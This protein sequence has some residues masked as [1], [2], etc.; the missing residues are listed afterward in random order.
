M[1]R[2]LLVCRS[3]QPFDWHTVRNMPMGGT[4]KC[5]AF[6]AEALA[7]RGHTVTLATTD[8]IIEDCVRNRSHDFDVVIAQNAHVFPVFPAATKKLWW[9]HHFS[10]QDLASKNAA[11]ARHHATAVVTLS[12]CH[13]S[14]LQTHLGI[15]STVIGHGVWLKDM[16]QGVKDPYRLIYASTPF[17]GLDLI[18]ALFQKIKAREPRATMAI[19]SGMGIYGMADQD[20]QYQSLYNNLRS[21]AGVEFLGALNQTRLY[22]EYAKAAIFFYPCTWPE[23]YCLALDEA[24][25]HGCFSITTGVGALWERASVICRTPDEMVTQVLKCFSQKTDSAPQFRASNWPDVAKQWEVL[26]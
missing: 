24:V 9:S 4:E 10:N 11:I 5:F 22:E 1:T 17:R 26:F 15:E 2:V 21:L 7:M 20:S 19:C 23:T 6:L 16:V 13:Q 14:D 12:Q 25:A 8:A 18:P 3:P